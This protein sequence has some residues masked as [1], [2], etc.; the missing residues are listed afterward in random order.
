M[1]LRRQKGF[2]LVEVML[3][4]MIIGV[5]AS[6]VPPI[7]ANSIERAKTAEAT[8]ALGSIRRA[9]RMHYVEYGT[10]KNPQFMAGRKVTFGRILT[11]TDT[12]L[13]G[14]YFSSDCYTFERVKRR[15]FRIKCKGAAS[16]AP[17]ADGVANVTLYINQI[18]DIWRG[19]ASDDGPIL[20]LAVPAAG[21]N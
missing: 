17:A 13:E 9:M 11:V 2:T 14:R 1:E 8:A 12:D 5:L 4:I 7:L 20:R 10:Y 18:G 6:T 3:T 15:T 21:R 16:S 19:G